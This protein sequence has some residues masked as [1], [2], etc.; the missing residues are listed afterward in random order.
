MFFRQLK[1]MKDLNS[2]KVDGAR[3]SDLYNGLEKD[4]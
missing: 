2:I 4:R 3:V 1:D